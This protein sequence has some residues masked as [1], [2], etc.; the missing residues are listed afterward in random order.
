MEKQAHALKSLNFSYKKDE[1]KKK[2]VVIFPKNMLDELQGSINTDQLYYK[3]KQK[4]YNFTEYFLAIIFSKDIHEGY[5][6]L[7]NADDEQSKFANKWKNIVKGV[8]SVAKKL[9]LSNIELFFSARQNVLNNFRNRLVPLKN[10]EP[11]PELAPNPEL[12]PEPK[13]RKSVLK[14]RE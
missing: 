1:S 2:I 4:N 10:L 8:K 6:S 11:E 3:S 5:L 14:S 9:F 13:H 7:K 12:E